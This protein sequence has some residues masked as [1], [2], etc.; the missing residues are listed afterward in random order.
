[1]IV[2]VREAGLMRSRFGGCGAALAAVLLAASAGQA[3]PR[4]PA[5][6]AKA[7]PASQADAPAPAAA[8]PSDA[9]AAIPAG[10]GPMTEAVAAVINDE[11]ISTYDLR[12]RVRLLIISSGVQV[13]EQNLPEIERE[14]L[15]GLVDERLQLQEI[16]SVEKKQKDVHL[17]PSTKEVDAEVAEF[18]RQFKVQPKQLVASLKNAGVDE[19]TLRDQITTSIAWRRYI[20]GRFRDNVH[21][22]DA[23]ID[24]AISRINASSAKPQYLV[25]EVFL[26]ASR[27]GG[28]KQAIDGA[29]QL[30]EQIRKGAPFQAVARQFSSLPTAANGGDSG[31]LVSGELQP[32]LE[33][34]LETL[35]PGQT[36][37]PIPVT[38][39]VYILQLRDKRAGGSTETVTLK[40]AAVRL[41]PD[42]PADQ[43]VAAQ[44]KLT[45]LKEEAHGCDQLAATGAK[46][47]GVIVGD[48]GEVSPGDLS[49]DF[50]QV[51]DTLK[52]GQIGG[53]VRTGA[54]LHLLAVC[55]RQA[56]GGRSP[57]R[58]DV[59]NRLFGEQLSMI[60]RRYLRDL[61]NSAAIETR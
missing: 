22:N 5:P 14:A 61:R 58:A 20:G 18:A 32:V 44:A 2:R 50:R 16:R 49:P 29:T 43:V 27:V 59:E 9:P 35:R 7:K 23:Q 56:G 25:S 11:I 41:A 3:A 51:V 38:D 47:S 28:E 42:A 19:S 1:M 36:S 37:D 48:L 15:R 40:Q 33:K 6:P 17:M 30:V 60:E 4:R 45:A 13:T 57:S 12:Q 54:G 53:P 52:P 46:V 55:S 26:D 39:G 31:W 34:S 21:V 24:A 10:P 8:A